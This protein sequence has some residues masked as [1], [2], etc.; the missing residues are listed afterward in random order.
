MQKIVLI[1]EIFYLLIYLMIP[2]LKILTFEQIVRNAGIKTIQEMDSFIQNPAFETIFRSSI[3]MIRRVLSWFYP[4]K[5]W[6]NRNDLQTISEWI[7]MYHTLR[8]NVS[9]R[10]MKLCKGKIIGM[11]APEFFGLPLSPRWF[12]MSAR[13]I[14][15]TTNPNTGE[16]KIDRDEE[17]GCHIC[18]DERVALETFLSNTFEAYI[19]RSRAMYETTDCSKRL[20]DPERKKKRFSTSSDRILLSMAVLC[21]KSSKFHVKIIHK[22]EEILKSVIFEVC[23]FRNLSQELLEGH[24]RSINGLKDF[25]SIRRSNHCQR[26]WERL[27]L[28]LEETRESSKLA[29][30]GA[31][32]NLQSILDVGNVGL[33]F[34]SKDIIL[35][36]KRPKPGTKFTCLKYSMHDIVRDRHYTTLSGFTCYNDFLKINSQGEM[37]QSEYRLSEIFIPPV[38]SDPDFRVSLLEL[39]KKNLDCDFVEIEKS[40]LPVHESRIH[41][42]LNRPVPYSVESLTIINGVFL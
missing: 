3:A 37:V 23:V 31:C 27:D 2:S 29:C 21:H 39:V 5:C 22:D 15:K 19:P 33:E 6:K 9:Y 42:L 8:T 38:L 24:L 35:H 18:Y 28:D 34:L 1:F 25:K 10:M 30:L 14:I 16:V 17:K 4:E 26:V 13:C 41:Q 36:G 7:H 12:L 40:D 32:Y 20:G 11:N